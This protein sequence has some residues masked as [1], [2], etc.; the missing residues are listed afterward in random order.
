MSMRSLQRCLPYSGAQYA[1]RQDKGAICFNSTRKAQEV[2][3]EM[4]LRNS[5]WSDKVMDEMIRLFKKQEGC[6]VV[7]DDKR[8]WASKTMTVRKE[9]GKTATMAWSV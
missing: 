1:A 2:Q 3:A 7:N 5:R 8:A 9:D 4:R 6:R